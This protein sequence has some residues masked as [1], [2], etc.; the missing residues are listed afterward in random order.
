MSDNFS[1]NSTFNKNVTNFVPK[2]IQCL[3]YYSQKTFVSDLIAGVTVGLVALPLAM[4][5][6]IASGVPPQAGI[7]TAIIAGFLISSLGGSKVQIGGPTGAFIVVVS[8]IVARYGMDGLFT[9]TFMAGLM[10]VVLGLGRFGS[11]VKYIPR[12]V[13]I[14]FTNGIAVLIASTQIKDFFGL[15]IEK[16]PGD[17]IGRIESLISHFSTYS[18]NATFLSLISLTTLILLRVSAPKLPAPIVV[19]VVGT[20][21]S[22]F[23]DLPVQTIHSQFGEIPTALPQLHLPTIRTDLLLTL[24]S[25]A[26]TV[27]MLGAIESLLSAV[28][29]DRMSGDRHN[30]NMELFAQGIA[31]LASPLFGGL[32]ATGAIARTTT[33]IRSGARTPIAGMIHA[34]TLLVILLIAAPL[35]GH[36]PLG[37]LASI[38]LMVAYNMGEWAQIPEILRLSRTS[39]IVWAI[40][41]S[42]TVFADLTVAVEAGLAMA[43]LLYIRKVTNTT[44][45]VKVTAQHIESDSEHSLHLNPLPQG[46]VMYRIHGSFLFGAGDKLQLIYDELQSLPSVVVIRLRNMNAIDA[47]GLH[48]FENLARTLRKSGRT[49]I[50]CGMREQPRKMFK[51]AEFHEIIG[52]KN[53]CESLKAASIRATELLSQNTK[54]ISNI[55]QGV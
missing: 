52:E 9:C 34:I 29:A 55:S 37:I 31:N 33:N 1:S 2:S 6:A 43:A 44:T 49:M 24:L 16:V 28:V 13:I 3:R 18:L 20:C 17:F 54:E 12:P 51:N 30:S 35:A 47:T 45:L 26:I 48:E 7:H 50:V 11:A 25:P 42:L 32:P 38:L 40:T 5:F 21:I 22:A 23:L 46:T 8:G 15:V 36:I 19:L 53:I 14:G 39:I 27:A 4:A 41:F 10:L